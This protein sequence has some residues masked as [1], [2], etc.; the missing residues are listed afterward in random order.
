[1]DTKNDDKKES[2]KKKIIF[3]IN[4]ISGGKSTGNIPESIA[5]GIDS[6]KFEYQVIFTKFAGHAN[7][8][9]KKAVEAKSDIIVAVG[10]DGTVNEVA[11]CLIHQSPALGIIPVGSG[12]G[13]ARHLG[14]PRTVDKAI[15]LINKGRYTYIDTA[16]INNK[17]FISI[18][19]VGYDALIAKKFSKSKKRGFSSYLKVIA[20][21][22]IKYKP[23]KY[24]ITVNGKTLNTKALFI[25]FANS[26][27][28]GYNAQI[29]P[30]A[31][32]ND[33]ILDL[34]IAKK[35][36]LLE[37]P[38]VANLV[39]LKM[40]DKS[41]YVSIIPAKEVVIERKKGKFVNIDG[42]AIK[43]KKKL[44]VKVIPSSLKIMI[45][46]YGKK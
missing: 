42:E 9:A 36:R 13:L 34:C 39:L 26:N 29:A 6:E 32:L 7:K 43:M 10:G 38:V 28:F 2:I 17:P 23:K 21:S 27:Q 22:F 35:P 5:S 25:S 41:P 46:D 14:I 20:L 18:A 30:K 1:M 33:G 11:S 19:G 31:K 45:S 40:I 44:E 15:Q 16:A 4:P 24:K 12:N 8:I 37:M 3:I